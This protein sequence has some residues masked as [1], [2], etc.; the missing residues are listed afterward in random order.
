MF[1]RKEAKVYSF[2]E[3]N[4]A[5]SQLIQQRHNEMRDTG[6]EI[7]KLLSSSNRVLKV[8]PAASS[9]QHDTCR[10]RAA[11]P[12]PA[13]SDTAASVLHKRRQCWH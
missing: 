5:F 10:W 2:E 11:V 3:L 4:D 8:R 7:T 1:E 13:Q 12:V 6:K 9:V